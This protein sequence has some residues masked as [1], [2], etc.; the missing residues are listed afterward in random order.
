MLL[1]CQ[2]ESEIVKE[3][4]IDTPTTSYSPEEAIENGDVVNL[5][6]EISNLQRFET[7]I[8]KVKHDA[9]DEIRITIYTVEGAPIFYNLHYDGSKI[10]YTYDNSQ[11]GFA[12]SE[13]GIESTSC[14]NIVSKS[15]ENGVKYLLSEC[16][17]NVGDTFDFLVSE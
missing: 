1:G 14:S 16:S 11:D 6:G 8:E 4:E 13:K 5:H 3:N 7:F 15:V 12:G 2:Q 9:E 10:Q 17:S